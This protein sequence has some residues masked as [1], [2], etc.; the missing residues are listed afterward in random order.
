VTYGPR[1]LKEPPLTWFGINKYTFKLGVFIQFSRRRS[2]YR[3]GSM[4]IVTGKVEQARRRDREKQR[5]K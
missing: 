3:T 2:E 1:G 4:N 5:Q